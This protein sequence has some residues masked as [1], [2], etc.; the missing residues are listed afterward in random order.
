MTGDARQASV[1]DMGHA[2]RSSMVLADGFEECS[3]R[4]SFPRPDAST[5]TSQDC[6][7]SLPQ[8]APDQVRRYILPAHISLIARPCYDAELW[9]S[10][11]NCV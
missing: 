7:I 1:S 5:L 2:P 4:F 10:L 11:S 6:C 8:R 3:L 9:A